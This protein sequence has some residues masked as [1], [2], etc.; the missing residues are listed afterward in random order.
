MHRKLLSFGSRKKWKVLAD[1][2]LVMF[3]ITGLLAFGQTPVQADTA[4]IVTLQ[5]GGTIQYYDG[6]A[7][8]W[9]ILTGPTA[10]LPGTY[11]F[12]F[13][14][15]QTQ[16]TISGSAITKS[17]IILK[18]KDH[19][20]LGLVGGKARG[21]YG[22][23]YGTW[24][25]PGSTDANGLL[26]VYQDGLR[27]TMSYEMKYNNT[28]QVKT[29]DVSANS[30]FEFNTNLLT[31]RLETCGGT[32]LDGGKASGGNGS[33]FTTWWFPGD[34]TGSGSNAPGETA[35]EFFPG[36]YSFQMQYKATVDAKLSVVIP[37]AD[38]LLTWQ[39]TKVTLGYSGQI[40][41]GGG[42]GDS[43]W[44][45]KPS[46]ELLPGMY[47]F[48]FDNYL[49]SLAIEGCEY[50]GNVAIVKLID[51][52][53][54]GIAGA[55]AQYDDGGWQDIPGTTDTSGLLPTFISG[56]KSNIAF[57]VNYAGARIEKTQNIAVDSVVVFQTTPPV[58]TVDASAGEHG[59]VTPATQTVDSGS[60]ATINITPATGYHIASITDNGAPVT[61][62]DPD[63]TSY[64][65]SN[66]I[67][68][69]EVVVTFAIDL[70]TLTYTAGPNGSI[71]GT[72]P[73]ND[74][75]Y[76]ASGSEVVAV[77]APNY[78]FL[79]WSD[80][81]PTA[82]R[83]DTNVTDNITATANFAI[84]LH[85]LTYIAGAG[86][87]IVGTNP[88]NDVAYGASGTE[89]IATPNEGY[90]FL[91]WSD[92]FPTATRTDTNVTD[93]ITATASFA[94]PGSA[95]QDVLDELIA[96]RATVTDKQDGNKLDEAIKHLEK[97]L[98][99]AWWTDDAHLQVKDGEKVFNEE[100]DAV[101]QLRDLIKGKKSSISDMTL[102][103][104]VDRIVAVDRLLAVV[105]IADATGGDSKDIAKANDEL[106][107][108]DNETAK[109]KYDSGIE[110]YR[111]AWKFVQ[112]AI[113]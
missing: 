9:K 29:Q 37:D 42:T 33:T 97:S 81:F 108:G 51:S 45:T 13:G 49:V 101:N 47:K 24:F 70:H 85:T 69:H 3:V 94:G 61:I 14:S 19:A 39:T 41:Y 11:T 105:A 27:T 96:L 5:Y 26:F 103:S 18:L 36:T 92:G 80:G 12:Q 10:I 100:K 7:S 64:L 98:T 113:K 68:A 30:V 2:F 84:D 43:T 79:S 1:V 99:P 74:V 59:S 22:T 20:D 50:T 57:A 111:N 23:S 56:S 67:A 82:T 78:H 63:M 58:I 62:T 110:H 17:V 107:K 60:G 89:V 75:E 40:K 73:Q 104:F 90:H 66:V 83:T 15:Y 71:T 4:T 21:G 55:T 53:G 25:V 8:D 77:A 95:K 31:L 88:Q 6:G 44:F 65:I 86:G 106:G 35:A 54:T 34:V 38:T 52:A 112:K 32:P 48:K 72:N 76:G 28:T 102:Q 109:G 93:N 91:S 87:S 46:M 16:F